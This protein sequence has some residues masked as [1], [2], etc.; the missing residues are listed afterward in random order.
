VVSRQNADIADTLH[1]RDVVMATT[2]R[3]SIY[4]GA[5]WRHLAN[6]TE[7]SMCGSD[8]VLSNYFDHLL[9]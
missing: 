2:F 1:P 4:R 7:P 5:H 3:L 9:L 6:V 8:V